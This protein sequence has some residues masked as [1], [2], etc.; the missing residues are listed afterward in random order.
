[1]Q[2]LSISICLCITYVS[3]IYIYIYICILVEINKH[4]TIKAAEV[5]PGRLDWLRLGRLVLV[6]RLPLACG[7]G[8]H[9]G[10]WGRCRKSAGDITIISLLIREH[11]ENM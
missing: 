1:M 8:L 10:E 6:H 11:G 9:Q 2:Y 3:C 4:I 5:L 7:S